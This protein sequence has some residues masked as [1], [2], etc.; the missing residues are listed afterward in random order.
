VRGVADLAARSASER[1]LATLTDLNKLDYASILP[2]VKSP[3]VVIDSDLEGAADEARLRKVVPQLRLITLNG[4][5]SFPMLDDS[6]RFNS[7]LIQ[8]IDSL[9][10][11]SDHSAR[12]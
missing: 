10:P 1:G 2:A 3:I 11:R 8:A 12:P 9:A 4:D 6:Q 7:T 5:D